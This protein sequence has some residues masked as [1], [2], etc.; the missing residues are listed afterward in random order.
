MYKQLP[1]GVKIGITRSIVVSFEK[2]MKDI[3]WNEENFDMQQFVEQW[4]Q[5]L[6]TKST[7]IDKVDDELKGHPDFHQALAMKVNEKINEFIN[8]KS[9]EE[10]IEQLKRNKMKHA[11]EMCKLEAEYHI[12]RLLV[13]K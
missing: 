8:E 6:Y 3:E 1:H 12:E 5:Y 4:K 2:Y 13:T 9:S 11:E 10:Q 7:W